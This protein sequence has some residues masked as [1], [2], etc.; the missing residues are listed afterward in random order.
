MTGSSARRLVAVLVGLAAVLLPA[1]PALASSPLRTA[2]VP[3]PDVHG[4][5]VPDTRRALESWNKGVVITFDP[6]LRQLPPGATESTV[7]A[8][9]AEQ[10]TTPPSELKSA[11]GPRVLV[12]LGALMPDLTGLNEQA[13]RSALS[14][15]GLT[16]A[17]DRTLPADWVVSSQPPPGTVVEFR[18][19]VQVG[20][21]APP[22]VAPPTVVPP[23]PPPRPFPVSLP[24]AAGAGGGVLLLLVLATVLVARSV[25]HSRRRKDRARPREHIEVRAFPGQVTGPDVFDL[26][27]AAAVA[28]APP[29]EV[30]S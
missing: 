8:S 9:R 16:L 17:A 29:R 4:L 25:R 27:A 3:L 10:V 28:S 30:R 19:P 7:V 5:S 12:T 24:V 15:R 23:P 20:F 26:P 18:P 6:D 21:V 1:A 11:T 13:A 22:V 2:P 14:D